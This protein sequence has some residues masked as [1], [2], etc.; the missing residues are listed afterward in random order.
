MLESIGLIVNFSILS[1]GYNFC[2]FAFLQN[3]PGEDPVGYKHE[4]S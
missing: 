3:L 1:V 4:F 2:I